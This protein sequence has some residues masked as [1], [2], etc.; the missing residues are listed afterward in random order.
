MAGGGTQGLSPAF[1]RWSIL[2]FILESLL[3]IAAYLFLLFGL[4]WQASETMGYVI[5]L[6]MVLGAMVNIFVLRPWYLKQQ[7]GRG[8]RL[9]E[10]GEDPGR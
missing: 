5:I 3:V 10:P 1:R 2:A 8:G 9:R 6:I 4:G 7:E